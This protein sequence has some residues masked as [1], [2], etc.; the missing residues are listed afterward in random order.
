MALAWA[1][2]K[3]QYHYLLP[4][5][6]CFKRITLHSAAMVNGDLAAESKHEKRDTSVV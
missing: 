2:I 4:A 1:K 6:A 3:P 5:G